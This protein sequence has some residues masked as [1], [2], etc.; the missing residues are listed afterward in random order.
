MRKDLLDLYRLRDLQGILSAF[1]VEEVAKTL[2]FEDAIKLAWRMLFDDYGNYEQNEYGVN[3]IFAIKKL[4]RERWDF[5]WRNE[6]LL[7]VAC[8]NTYRYEERNDALRKAYELAKK[9]GESEHSGLL[10]SLADCHNSPE[11]GPI[12]YDESIVLIEKAMRDKIY[13]DGACVLSFI[14]SCKGDEEGFEKWKSIAEA[15]SSQDL[16]PYVYP[17]FLWDEEI[18]SSKT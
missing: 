3:L 13:K 12:S 16:S 17:K 7:G 4:R 9:I 10:I 8:E 14:Y 5:D 11:K 18:N 2:T 15:M 6:A 1:E